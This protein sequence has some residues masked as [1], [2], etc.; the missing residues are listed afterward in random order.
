VDT[1]KRA[2]KEK[3]LARETE[4]GAKRTAEQLAETAVQTLCGDTTL[5]GDG[6]RMCLDIRP[7]T[8]QVSYQCC[9][10]DTELEYSWVCIS[11]YPSCKTLEKP[12]WP[13]EIT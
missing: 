13:S 5:V 10:V 9:S 7:G 8:M 6:K 4:A 1:R 2:R 12:N 11:V 3:A